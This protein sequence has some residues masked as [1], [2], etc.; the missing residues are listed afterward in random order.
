MGLRGVGVGDCLEQG[1]TVPWVKGT[2]C[3]KAWRKKRTDKAFRPKIKLRDW[4]A[5]AGAE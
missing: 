2:A 3:A 5:K 1:R 4:G